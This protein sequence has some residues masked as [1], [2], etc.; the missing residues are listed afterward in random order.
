MRDLGGSCF[1]GN[2]RLATRA[3]P[4]HELGT[5]G[6]VGGRLSRMLALLW[7]VPGVAPVHSETHAMLT[8]EY[9]MFNIEP[10]MDKPVIPEQ[11][12]G[13]QGEEAENGNAARRRETRLQNRD[14]GRDAWLAWKSL[15]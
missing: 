14:G 5:L 12:D 4:L 8:S 13:S 1:F 7:A 10:V 6:G 2:P 9:G 3:P 15:S 11:H